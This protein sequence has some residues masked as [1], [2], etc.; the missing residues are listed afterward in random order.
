M[1]AASKVIVLEEG[2]KD[3]DYMPQQLTMHVGTDASTSVNFA[4]TTNKQVNTVLK[5]NKKGESQPT[6]VNGTNV[7]RCRRQI[8]PQS[9]GNRI[10]TWYRV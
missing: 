10:N 5:V 9:R 2:V 3:S 8:L 6:I 7:H 1:F 4:W